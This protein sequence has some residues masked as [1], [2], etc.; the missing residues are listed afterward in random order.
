[1][2]CKCLD[3]SLLSESV[4]DWFR[5][6]LWLR[7]EGDLDV[8]CLSPDQCQACEFRAHKLYKTFYC[9][10]HFRKA[11][12][13]PMLLAFSFEA[14]S[15][16]LNY[17]RYDSAMLPFAR[18]AVSKSLSP[19][20]ESLPSVDEQ[21]RSIYGPGERDLELPPWVNSYP[22]VAR[23]HLKG[24]SCQVVFLPSAPSLG[25]SQ[26]DYLNALPFGFADEARNLTVLVGTIA[27]ILGSRF[28][29]TSSGAPHW[30]GYWQRLLNEEFMKGLSLPEPTGTAL[31]L[32]DDLKRLNF[33]AQGSCCGESIKWE[34]CH[35][36]SYSAVM[37]FVKSRIT[38]PRFVGCPRCHEIYS[39]V[40]SASSTHSDSSRMPPSPDPTLLHA[41]SLATEVVG[42]EQDAVRYV[43]D[44]NVHSTSSPVL[45]QTFPTQYIV[46]ES[47]TQKDFWDILDL[48][49]YLKR[50]CPDP[51]AS[52]GYGSVYKCSLR[53]END[54]SLE[55]AVKSFRYEIPQLQQE[56]SKTLRREIKVWHK[57]RH[58]NIVPLL[59][60]ARGF[61]SAISTVSPW[62]SGGPLH[63]YLDTRD[64]D[65]NL[66]D[67]FRLLEGV[68][69]GLRYLHS[70]PVVHGDLS[71]GNVLIDNDG[72]ARLSD[73][74]L[75]AVLGG[76]NGGSSFA[77][78]ACRPG[79][80]KYAAPELVLTPDSV[81][82]SPAS[83]IFSFGC[84]MLQVLS[85]QPP[86]GQMKEPAITLALD[87]RTRAPRPTDGSIRDVDWNFIQWCWLNADVRPKIGD[88]VTYISDV[89]ASLIEDCSPTIDGPL[90]SS[91]SPASL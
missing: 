59:G 56:F 47:T 12:R 54:K 45:P 2:G 40:M 70:F 76:L 75:C 4:P 67:R 17:I 57:L 19:T 44:F 51:V 38:D 89:L 62:I 65:L 42:R 73:F 50:L 61:A 8:D 74:G 66:S 21:L 25:D 41:L 33:I 27:W 35:W 85:G 22:S 52:G 13:V 79:T 84:I 46:T 86:W 60:I 91:E 63:T 30:H 58:D 31:I 28:L 88:V 71:S 10:D 14:F 49:N 6:I 87:K 26:D 77:L 69:A 9:A 7:E 11:P 72:K 82:P 39:N 20:S 48:T 90:Q 68:A 16:I 18:A 3:L 24:Y 78:T 5:M 36:T 64:A 53:D 29:D 81:Q 32:R 1:M 80:I 43:A 83:D 55:V 15:T 37:M 23:H 34:D